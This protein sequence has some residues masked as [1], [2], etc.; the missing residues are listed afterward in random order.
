ML[1]T[2]EDHLDQ[3]QANLK[4]QTINENRSILIPIMRINV[5]LDYTPELLVDST[6][7]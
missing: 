7:T 4:S 2:I 5:L 6:N 1:E 3:G